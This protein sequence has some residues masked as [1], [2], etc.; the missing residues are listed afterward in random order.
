MHIYKNEYPV[1]IAHLLIIAC[2]S[3]NTK[4]WNKT[5]I[6]HICSDQVCRFF[7]IDKCRLH[8]DFNL[9]PMKLYLKSGRM[10]DQHG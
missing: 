8:A 4:V 2:L 3:A 6:Y 5:L 9:Q 10:P 1:A 7:G